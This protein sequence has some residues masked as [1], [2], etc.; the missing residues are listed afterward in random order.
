M[1]KKV[2]VLV[3]LF[4]SLV[5]FA[6]AFKTV[7]INLKIVNERGEAVPTSRLH[8]T[9]LNFNLLTCADGEGKFFKKVKIQKGQTLKVG[10]SKNGYKSIIK[11]DFSSDIDG[12]SVVILKKINK[13]QK[14]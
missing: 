1:K 3:L 11:K 14:K 6:G 5:I 2:L 12:N 13:R 8:F 10:I 7:K 4:Y 9:S